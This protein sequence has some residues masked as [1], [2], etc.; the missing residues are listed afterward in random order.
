[1]E[2]LSIPLPKYSKRCDY[3]CYDWPAKQ[4]REI[5]PFDPLNVEEMSKNIAT[6]EPNYDHLDHLCE[7]LTALEIH[8]KIPYKVET[9]ASKSYELFDIG[10]TE[11]EQKENL[12]NLQQA[13]ADL[14]AKKVKVEDARHLGE[15]IP[16]QVET[17]AVKSCKLFDIGDT[18]GEI[19][20]K[21]NLDNLIPT[22]FQQ[23]YDD[24]MAKQLKVEAQRDLGD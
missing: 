23:A 22:N 12:D 20:K 24:I 3:L 6:T 4:I 1:V 21:E 16:F 8:E 14:M 2:V 10:Y 13:Y 9:V 11:D 7:I 17:V 15:K 18:E 19:Y 5:S